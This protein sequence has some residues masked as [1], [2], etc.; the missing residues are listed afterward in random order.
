MAKT[1]AIRP[2]TD[3]HNAFYGYDFPMVYGELWVPQIAQG[4]MIRVGRYISL[5]DIE[6]QL[7]PNNYMY[8]H[9]ITYTLD[10]YTNEGIQTTLAITKQFMLQAGI[11]DGTETTVW[12]LGKREANLF[13]QNGLGADPLYSGSTFK[14]DPGAQP[15]GTL[16]GRYQSLDGRD[17]VNICANG[18]NKGQ[19]GY[20]NLQWYGIT[21]YHSFDKH[22]HISF[23]TYVEHQNGVPNQNNAQAEYIYQ[24]GGTPFSPQYIPYN[25]PY[26]AQCKN[27]QAIRCSTY[28]IGSVFYLNY[29]PEPLDNFSVRGEYYDDPEGQRTGY[30]TLYHDV[31][32]GWQHWFSP[33]IE[34]RPEFTYYTSTNNAFDDGTKKEERVFSGDIIL[35]Y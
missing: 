4:L 34:V 27:A 1:I 14:K 25:S 13:V 2:P 5:P 33:Q 11:S 16:C 10:N 17:D 20:N 18:I 3:S 30:A 9:S 21:A 12:N 6:A 19:W 26:L 8:T 23:E 22:W 7:A 29:S 15:T 32:I 28:S 24:N 31:G 35:H